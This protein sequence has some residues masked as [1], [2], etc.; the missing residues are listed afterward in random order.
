MTGLSKLIT[1]A[2]RQSNDD[3]V[4]ELDR[5]LRDVERLMDSAQES[6]AGRRGDPQGFR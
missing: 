4:G 3:L 2:V 6:G 1:E 5:I